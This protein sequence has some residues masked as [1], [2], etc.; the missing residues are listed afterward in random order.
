MLTAQNREVKLVHRQTNSFQPSETDISC[1]QDIILTFYCFLIFY[2][3]HHESKCLLQL[4]LT[5]L[6][7]IYHHRRQR[8][9]VFLLKS[10][11][12]KMAKCLHGNVDTLNTDTDGSDESNQHTGTCH[13]Y[14]FTLDV[15]C[16]FCRHFVGRLL[17]L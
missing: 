12:P 8:K 10:V 9:G 1:F 17:L 15:L 14:L 13:L 3:P 16:L 5:F 4:V 11:I 7:G 6:K 2:K